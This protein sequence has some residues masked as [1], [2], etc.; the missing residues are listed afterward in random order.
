V[1]DA[2]SPILIVDDAEE[3][4]AL[5]A[6]RLKALG[7]KAEQAKN[8][9]E[10]MRMLAARPFDLV[11]L[12]IVMPEMDGYQVLS[13]IKSDSRFCDIPVIVISA[14]GE[15]DSVVRCIHLGAED[16]LLK[17]FNPTLLKARI[18]A[19]LERKRLRDQEQA[20]MR[21]IERERQKS[22]HLLLNIMPGSIAERLKA[23]E[24]VIANTHEAVTVMFTDIVNFTNLSS[25][26]T[27][28]ELVR[29]LNGIVSRFDELAVQFGVEK[30]KTIGDGVMFVCGLPCPARITPGS[31][32]S[33]PCGSR[34]KSANFPSSGR[35]R[36][37]C[38][39]ASIPAPSWPG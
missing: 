27:A 13:A 1:D 29:K 14:V 23:G 21:Q 10:A 15:M 25:R 3:L 4:R 24:Q 11:L 2:E 18:E 28:E 6:V 7:L 5:L 9:R 38:A 34:A 22:D 8:G 30:I 36:W 35:C 17:P 31:W 20:L 32:R 16:Y 12:D 37:R 33:W 39:S 19:G 26:I